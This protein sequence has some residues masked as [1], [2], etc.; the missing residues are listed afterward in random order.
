MRNEAGDS[1]SFIES[2]HSERQGGL[3]KRKGHAGRG[4][5]ISFAELAS[6]A[7][8]SIQSMSGI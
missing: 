7:G 1:I 3:I 8:P 6:L 2:N 5:T 4:I